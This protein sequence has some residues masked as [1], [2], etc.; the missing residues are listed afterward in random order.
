MIQIRALRRRQEACLW[1]SFS[2]S[3]L[4]FSALR[5]TIYIALSRNSGSLVSKTSSE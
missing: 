1:S 4:A 2:A 3:Y 5:V